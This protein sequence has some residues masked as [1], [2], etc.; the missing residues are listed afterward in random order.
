M[1][2][3]DAQLTTIPVVPTKIGDDGDG[4]EIT[5]FATVA[6]V[7]HNVPLQP[8]EQT[9][10]LLVHVPFDPHEMVHDCDVDGWVAVHKLFATVAKVSLR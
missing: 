7:V 8:A 10:A 2:P 4:V 9:H 5:A 1:L 3:V 6:C